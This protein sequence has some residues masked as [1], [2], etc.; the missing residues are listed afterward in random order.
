M[1]T[2]RFTPGQMVWLAVLAA[3]V[4]ASKAGL[5]LPLKIPG[6]AGLI[7]MALLVAAVTLLPRR[8]TAT[9]VGIVSGVIAVASG[10]GEHGAAVTF[11]SYAAT[12]VG[13]ELGWWLAARRPP[14]LRAACAGLL[15]NLTK[16]ALRALAN[17]WFG[18]PAG[19]VALGG[20]WSLTT[21]VLFGIAGGVLGHSLVLGLRRVGLVPSGAPRA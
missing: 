8:G 4:V 3:L 12:G 20:R 13:V 18:I 5:S 6:H 14:L 19:F 17:Q 9:L 2:A 1:T 7:T 16:L 10:A 21:T 15:G 11:A